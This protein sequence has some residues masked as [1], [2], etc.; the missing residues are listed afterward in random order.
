M[1][2]HIL[3]FILKLQQDWKTSMHFQHC[4][5]YQQHAREHRLFTENPRK[6]K[7]IPKPTEFNLYTAVCTLKDHSPNSARGSFKITV[8]YQTFNKTKCSLH[9]CTFTRIDIKYQEQ[10]PSL[11][12]V[13]KLLEINLFKIITFAICL[14][15]LCGL[16]MQRF[17]KWTS[18]HF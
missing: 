9:L 3:G 2:I 7:K 15:E 10:E 5:A 4:Q 6:L 11:S 16:L 1:E 13:I 17:S 18:F 8:K 14:Y 12:Q